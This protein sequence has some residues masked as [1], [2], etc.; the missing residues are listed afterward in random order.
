MKNL[1]SY[2]LKSKGLSGCRSPLLTI[3]S[4]K[5]NQRVTFYD[6][7]PISTE[8]KEIFAT[9]SKGA[10]LHPPFP[11]LHSCSIIVGVLE[12]A[13]KVSLLWSWK[14]NILPCALQQ[15]KYHHILLELR[16]KVQVCMPCWK[17]VLHCNVIFSDVMLPNTGQPDRYICLKY[18]YTR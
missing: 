8:E 4:R 7:D 18:N 2:H 1:V 17:C 16:E 15:I 11:G 5:E 6:S 9:N 10:Q 13:S 12:I 3:A 14:V